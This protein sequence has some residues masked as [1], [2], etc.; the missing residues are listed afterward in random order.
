[1]DYSEL[2]RLATYCKDTWLDNKW[3]NPLTLNAEQSID[4]VDS[5]YITAASPDVVLKLLAQ[6]QALLEALKRIEAHKSTDPHWASGIAR[7][8]IAAAEGKD[9]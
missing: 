1:M 4:A 5:A 8:A 9:V 2:K 3:H 7:A 6:N